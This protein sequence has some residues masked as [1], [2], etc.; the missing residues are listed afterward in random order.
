MTE[1]ITQDKQQARALKGHDYLSETTIHGYKSLLFGLPF[2][3]AGAIMLVL[4]SPINRGTHGD[5]PWQLVILIIAFFPF[6][7]IIFIGH[8]LR[9]I[10]RQQRIKALQILYAH[11]PWKWDSLWKTDGTSDRS[12]ATMY[13][14]FRIGIVFLLFLLPFNWLAFISTEIAMGRWFWQFVVG[15]FD[16]V[17]LFLFGYGTYLLLRRAKYGK[18]RVRF[19]TFPFFLGQEINLVFEGGD[20]LRNSRSFTATLRNIEE[21]YEREGDEV[22]IMCYELYSDKIFF[23]EP[24]LRHLKFSSLELKFTLPENGLDTR[25]SERPPR[26]WE[27]ELLAE[28]TGIDFRAFFLLPVYKALSSSTRTL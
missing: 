25:L 2:V 20:L 10:L 12:G 23:S 8:G 11:E 14:V 15:F 27:M 28:T 17:T 1:Q 16:L 18:R 7:G 9:G 4:A 26:Y 3:A 13:K 24:E 5:M 6:A 19:A 22:G 21:R